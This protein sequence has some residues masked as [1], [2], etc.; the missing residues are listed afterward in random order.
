MRVENFKELFCFLKNFSNAT[1]AKEN[2]AGEMREVI[3]APAPHGERLKITFR[4]YVSEI[5]TIKGGLCTYFNEILLEDGAEGLVSF[6]LYRWGRHIGFMTLKKSKSKG[7]KTWTGF[8][9]EAQ[10]NVKK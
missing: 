3:Y 8:G 6:A 9:R 4:P 7:A 10:K 5:E 1:A 2:D